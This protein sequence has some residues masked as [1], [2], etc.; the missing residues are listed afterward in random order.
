MNTV[1][2][3]KVT[4]ERKVIRKELKI[5]RPFTE[6]Y[7]YDSQPSSWHPWWSETC[8]GTL[9]RFQNLQT[10]SQHLRP[11]YSTSCWM[12]PSSFTVFLLPITCKPALAWVMEGAELCAEIVAT[13]RNFLLGGMGGEGVSCGWRKPILVPMQHN[14]T[15]SLVWH[16]E[17]PHG[18]LWV[19]KGSLSHV[20]ATVSIHSSGKGCPWTHKFWW[21]TIGK[22]YFN[23]FFPSMTFTSLEHKPNQIQGVIYTQ[24]IQSCT[25][26]VKTKL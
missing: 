15:C 19:E 12:C 24:A 2:L 26:I 11:E 25:P 7:F 10:G 4:T 21:E 20:V 17:S 16:P 8:L 22:L 1:P 13:W 9:L 5:S 3:V 14:P 23:H 18:F 6:T